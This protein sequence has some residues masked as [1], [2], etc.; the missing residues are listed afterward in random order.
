MTLVEHAQSSLEQFEA[1]AGCDGLYW[2]TV[3]DQVFG[4]SLEEYLLCSRLP[5]GLTKPSYTYADLKLELEQL[6]MESR[7]LGYM[8]VELEKCKSN[9]LVVT[10]TC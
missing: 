1:E 3:G 6:K 2:V 10:V 8:G 9:G 4:I 5:A 7:K